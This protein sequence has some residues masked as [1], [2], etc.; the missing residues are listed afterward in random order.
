MIPDQISDALAQGT[1]DPKDGV[2]LCLSGGGYRAMLFHVGSLWR[3]A[4]LD[5]LRD[6]TRISSVSGGSIT[7]G[8]LA[9]AWPK[10][11]AEG[12][13]AFIRDVAGPV[14]KLASVTIDE[15]AILGG[16][17]L[18]GSISAY[19]ARAYA[20]HLF[21]DATLQHLPEEPRFIFNATNLETGSL[22]RFTRR[23]IRD[24]R[25]GRIPA[26]EV[27]LAD[28]VAASSAFPPILSPFIL[29]VA[30]GDFDDPLPGELS[31][32][33]FRSDISLTDGGVYDNLG[34]QQVWGRCRTVLVSDAGGHIA[35]DPS[36][37]GDWARQST[38]VLEVIDQQVRNLRMIQ[39]VGS[40]KEKKRLGAFWS[41]RT[42]IADYTLADALAC[43]VEETTRLAAVPTR[44]RRLEAR[45][46]E[47]LINWGYAVADAGI[48]RYWQPQAAIPA[49]FPYPEAG[50]G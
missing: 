11:L 27:K 1:G 12:L 19:V 48:R 34:L 4:E 47:R 43:P 29:D 20:K 23:E 42:D 28:A 14:R 17:V 25:V 37:P 24:W 31:A 32:D 3:L 35:D 22:F 16:I 13:P 18:P 39:V 40:L 5:A 49:G 38:R 44:L 45:Q 33:A 8:V 10:L 15:R 7:A 6:L 26:P 30:P 21:G 2:G 41:V 50:I 36:P 46:Q 9:L